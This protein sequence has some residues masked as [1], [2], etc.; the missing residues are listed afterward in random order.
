V[1]AFATFNA[2]ERFRLL[3]AASGGGGGRYE[4]ENVKK[5]HMPGADG[6]NALAVALGVGGWQLPSSMVGWCVCQA[7][8]RW[9]VRRGVRDIYVVYVS[10]LVIA[11]V[12]FLK[13]TRRARPARLSAAQQKTLKE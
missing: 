10:L 9:G 8:G 2:D 12:D 13:K 3:Q 4:L 5:K 11:V 6:D 1:A 7:Q